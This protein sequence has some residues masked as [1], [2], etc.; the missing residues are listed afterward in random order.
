MSVFTS[1]SLAV[2]PQRFVPEDRAAA[3]SP[4]TPLT[5][6]EACP[7]HLDPV[8]THLC[9]PGPWLGGGGSWGGGDK[10][11]I[12]PGTLSPARRYLSSYAPKPFRVR[13][14]VC[15]SCF[16]S[17][18]VCPGAHAHSHAGLGCGGGWEASGRTPAGEGEM[19]GVGTAWRP[20]SRVAPS[21]DP[22]GRALTWAPQPLEEVR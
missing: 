5:L 17:W 22:E 3:G 10:G 19:P 13:R 18:C 7:G 6:S 1:S 11:E 4:A 16:V 14:A 9:G 8:L 20:G 15:A 21:W 12:F 2:G